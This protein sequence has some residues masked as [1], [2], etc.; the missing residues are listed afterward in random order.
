MDSIR[1]GWF[2]EINDLWPGQAMSLQ[3]EEVLFDE[4]SKFQDVMV[5]QTKHHGRALILDGVIQNTE[6]DEFSYQ[7]MVS[8]LPVNAHP[9]PEKVLII[10]GGDGG[11]ARELDR[12]PKVKEIVQCE[13]DG[14]VIE[15]SKK[16]M[17]S[18]GKGFDSPKLTL[19]VGD[20]F[21][22]MKEHQNEF[23]VIVTDSS[24]PVGPAKMLFE[25][26]YFEL[27]KNALRAGGIICSQGECMWLHLDLIKEMQEFCKEL[28]PVVDYSY[29]MVPTYPSGQIGY[30]LCSLNPETKFREP[31]H[32]FTDD[33]ANEIGWKYYNT[34]I[35]RAS[36]VL[37]NFAR[38]KLA[39]K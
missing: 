21:A 15:V 6:S 9:N 24:D 8:M 35:H 25:K 30:T 39:G 19:K 20:G 16:F 7:E 34:D 5:L 28:F 12:H 4:K 1:E 14:T 10:G 31:V 2:S 17:P 3:V 22:F 11:V 38:K 37:P 27:M 29:S 23:D 18:M 32:T 13:I 36:F 33:E 26:A